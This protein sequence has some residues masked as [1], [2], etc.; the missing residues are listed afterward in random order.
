MKL[1]VFGSTGGSGRQIV[2]QSLDAG[3]RVTA[4]ARNPVALTI[5]HSNLLVIKADVLQLQ[6]FESVMQQQDAVL[7]ALGF[8]SLKDVAVYS[9]GVCNITAAM[10]K[11]GV[12]RIL[13]VSAAAVETNPKLSFI[14]RILTKL[15]QHILKN[16]YADVLRMEKQLKK[17]NLNWTIV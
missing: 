2:Q 14:Y 7:S 16:P 13:C 10:N 8:R 15:L 5:Q 6:S 9:Q 1:I 11:Y 12:R 17:T 3:H 4:V